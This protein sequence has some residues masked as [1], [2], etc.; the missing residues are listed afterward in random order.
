MLSAE[1]KTNSVSF[2]VIV[3]GQHVRV[4][5]P[6][7]YFGEIAT[8]VTGTRYG[9]RSAGSGPP[10]CRGGSRSRRG[11]AGPASWIARLSTR[12]PSTSAAR[13]SPN[14][15]DFALVAMLGLLGLRIFEATSADITDRGGEHGTG[16]SLPPDHARAT[17]LSYSVFISLNA[18]IIA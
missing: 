6:G 7:D 4:L 3:D 14:Q 9:R 15:D 11:S 8:G 5:G 18:F 10:P 13:Q 1:L 12:P 16:L 17:A 2:G